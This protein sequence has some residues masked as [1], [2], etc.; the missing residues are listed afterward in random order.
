MGLKNRGISPV[1]KIKIILYSLCLIIL[2]YNIFKKKL[3]KRKNIMN[4]RKIFII[5][6]SF[7]FI[8]ILTSGKYGNSYY[9]KVSEYI[10]FNEDAFLLTLTVYYY[11]LHYEIENDFSLLKYKKELKNYAKYLYN[12][13]KNEIEQ[14][15]KIYFDDEYYLYLKYKNIS[16]NNTDFNDFK[17]INKKNNNNN[18]NNINNT[19]I[20]N[21]TNYIKQ[22]YIRK[23]IK[24]RYFYYFSDPDFSNSLYFLLKHNLSGIN[25]NLK[26]ILEIFDILKKDRKYTEIVKIIKNDSY[27]HFKNFLKRLNKFLLK[28]YKKGIE[29]KK[30][31]IYYNIFDTMLFSY[32]SAGWIDY[33]HKSKGIWISNI[34][35]DYISVVELMHLFF[36]NEFKNEEELQKYIENYSHFETIKNLYG[37]DIK[38]EFILQSTNIYECSINSYFLLDSFIFYDELYSNTFLLYFLKEN[39]LNYFTYDINITTF[40]F[41][42]FSYI[43]FFSQYIIDFFKNYKG[44]YPVKSFIKYFYNIKKE[45]II[46]SISNINKPINEIFNVIINKGK[47]YILNTFKKDYKNIDLTFID[48]TL[49]EK[50]FNFIPS[51]FSNIYYFNSSK[52][53]KFSID[54]NKFYNNCFSTKEK[55][56]VISSLNYPFFISTL[57][58]PIFDK[59]LA[60][61]SFL[62]LKKIY[63][64]KKLSTL[65]YAVFSYHD[66]IIFI[67]L[68]DINQL[69]YIIDKLKDINKDHYFKYKSNF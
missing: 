35:L 33:N 30:Y 18:N 52:N 24:N 42:N 9:N 29:F 68:N 53:I 31:K 56:I 44:K 57:T 3:K 58:K 11:N 23:L 36:R 22:Y 66:N 45:N 17:N 26:K 41:F 64:E 69:K 48:N 62:K 1:F 49:I 16:N 63:S 32:P 37:L 20:N 54:L 46:E 40:L 13:Y 7:L 43:E 34:Y 10:I 67:Y 51:Q 14:I 39:G 12:N 21:N 27:L 6:F 15:N 19:K 60:T 38:N 28:K 59:L 47:F 8:F 65:D 5:L 50:E 61:K 2:F 25:S 55:I 4:I